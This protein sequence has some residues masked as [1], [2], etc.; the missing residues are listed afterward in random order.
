MKLPTLW[1]ESDPICDRMGQQLQ[2]AHTEDLTA[3]KESHD[4]AINSLKVLPREPYC[5]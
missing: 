5:D 4:L 1:V 3:M 2:E